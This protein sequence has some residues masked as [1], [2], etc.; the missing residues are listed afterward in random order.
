MPTVQ[1]PPLTDRN[2][3]GDFLVS[4]HRSALTASRN[5]DKP[6]GHSSFFQRLSLHRQRRE[7][8][9][10]D[11]RVCAAAS[12]PIEQLDSCLHRLPRLK[13]TC[14]TVSV[15]SSPL[16]QQEQV[17]LNCVSQIENVPSVCTS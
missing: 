11:Y 4:A 7:P 13:H 3:E 16:P 5:T 10:R 1:P 17:F 15:G 12:A 14:L 6:R 9:T 2:T 8:R